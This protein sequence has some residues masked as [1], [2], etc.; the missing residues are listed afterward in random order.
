MLLS[1][2]KFKS[3]WERYLWSSAVTFLAGLLMVLLDN[4]GQFT[5]D[6]FKDGSFLGAL[7]VAV[8]AGVK[9]VFELW[10]AKLQTNGENTN[11]S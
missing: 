6:S 1:Y 2:E 4:W 10:L 9:A 7:F 11:N 3:N 5:L 8:R